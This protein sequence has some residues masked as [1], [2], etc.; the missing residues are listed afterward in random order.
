M[1]D[2]RFEEFVKMTA[3]EYR[4]PPPVPR[5]E[6]WREIVAARQKARQ[7][8]GRSQDEDG[9]RSEHRNGD[10]PSAMRGWWSRGG[11]WVTWG[12]PLAAALALGVL[13]GRMGRVEQT[14][15]Q[16]TLEAADSIAQAALEQYALA[17]LRDAEAFLTGFRVD[18]RTGRVDEGF[19]EPARAL[20][21]TTRLL[22]D[23]PA[24]EG[25]QL[26]TVLGDLE[27]VLTQIAQLQTDRGRENEELELIDHGIEQRGVMLK[28]RA[29]IDADPV[30]MVAQGVL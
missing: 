18:A 16:L 20:L 11:A 12:L 28:L 29:A 3:R 6:M 30:P 1:T 5:E 9:G 26:Q 19:G 10:A 8:G 15:P 21:T 25:V 2:D 7:P 14:P 23:T 13:I 27:L 24:G 4:D 22:L 17:H